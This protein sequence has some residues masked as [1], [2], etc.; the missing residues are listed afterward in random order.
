M[1]SRKL[2]LGCAVFLLAATLAGQ[3]EKL[4]V[5]LPS[6]A[7]NIDSR[8]LFGNSVRLGSWMP[9]EADIDGLEANLSQISALNE[10]RWKSAPHIEHPETYHRQYIGVT[11]SHQMRFVYVNAFCESPPSDWK[12]KLYVV[13]DGGPCFWQAFYDP[14]TKKFSNLMI[15]GRA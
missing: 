15:N 12:T 8:W 7:G 1:S 9:S 2:L 6:S 10:T 13:I 11:D 5:V 14:S 3:Q 4:Y